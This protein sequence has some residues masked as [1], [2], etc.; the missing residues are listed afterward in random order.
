MLIFMAGQTPI[1][2]K[3]IL[4]FTDPVFSKRAKVTS[5]HMS[6]R[7]RNPLADKAESVASDAE[8]PSEMEIEMEED[9]VTEAQG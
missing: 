7:L 2:G 9:V 3:Q 1:Y 6:D 4:Y 8:A 5:P